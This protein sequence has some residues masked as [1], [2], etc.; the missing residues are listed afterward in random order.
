MKYKHYSPNAEVY[1]VK[2]IAGAEKYFPLGEKVCVIAKNSGGKSFGG[3]M[4][5]DAGKNDEEYAA[6]QTATAQPACMPKCP[7][8]AESESRCVT[9]FSSRRQEE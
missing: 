7:E 3:A 1:V 2:N 4:V 9:D 8:K 6:R 5:Y